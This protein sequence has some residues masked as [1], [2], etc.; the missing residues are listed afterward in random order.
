MDA[1]SDLRKGFS[2]VRR[3]IRIIFGTAILLLALATIGVVNSPDIYTATT[4]VMVD[5]TARSVLTTER[6]YG[7]SG[8]ENSRVDGEV[9]LAKSDHV[10]LAVVKEQNLTTDREFGGSS[11]FIH[12]LLNPFAGAPEVLTDEQVVQRA[13]RRLSARTAVQRRGLTF[14]IAISVRSEE[15]EKAA[16]LANSI[17][18]T[19]IDNQLTAKIASAT[20]SRDAL[21]AHIG[22]TWQES[23]TAGFLDAAG[24]QLW[25]DMGPV[26]VARQAAAQLESSRQGLRDRLAASQDAAEQATL[27]AQLAALSTLQQSSELAGRHYQALLA[28]SQQLQAE[29]SLQLADSRIASPALPPGSPSGPNR[30]L[31]LVLSVLGAA[32]LGLALAALYERFIGGIITEGQASAVLESRL[33]VSM[34]RH[35]SGRAEQRSTS[36]ALM[37][38]PLSVFAEAVRRVRASVDQVLRRHPTGASGGHIIMVTSSSAGE[39]KTTVALSLARAYAL[40]GQRTLLID[41]DLRKPS[42]AHHLDIAPR[43]GL[44]DLLS[45]DSLEDRMSAIVGRDESTG[46]T[47]LVGSQASD[48]PTDQLI[49]GRAFQRLM[50]AA[51]KSFDIIILDTPPLACVVDGIYLTPFADLIVFVVRAVT[52]AQSEMRC[53]VEIL[54]ASKLEAVKVVGVLN[55]QEAPGK[56]Y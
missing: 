19:Y 43:Y 1:V 8:S 2:L 42:V 54:N 11:G 38:A 10:L 32:G 25:A 44:R 15:P 30:P 35:R 3:Q 4:I 33:M 51:R 22:A 16:R 31:L 5:P 18:Q 53:A 20:R 26:L 40:A 50:A 41:C 52:T 45:D 17:A 34:P 27:N 21:S 28:R 23:S 39:G 9:E 49:A 12:T 47:V 7:P 48:F 36:D 13:L 14:L 6:D 24:P 46:L 55:H 56:P 37:H 29:A